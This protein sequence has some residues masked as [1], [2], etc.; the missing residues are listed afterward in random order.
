VFHPPPLQSMLDYSS[1]FIFQFY[2]GGGK[3]QTAQGVHWFMFLGVDKGV[4]HGAWCLP[5]HSVT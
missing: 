5:V 4:P 3:D 1:L 2:L